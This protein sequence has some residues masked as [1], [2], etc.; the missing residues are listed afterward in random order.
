MKRE[1]NEE[2]VKLLKPL[3][4]KLPWWLLAA[5]AIPVTI[6]FLFKWYWSS[7][8]EIRKLMAETKLAEAREKAEIGALK[9]QKPPPSEVS[10]LS[11]V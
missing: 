5:I 7:Y 6:G 3:T 4:D 9:E 10:D 8:W 1:M 11:E 2:V